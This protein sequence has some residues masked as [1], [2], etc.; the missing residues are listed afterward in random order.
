M[1]DEFKYEF[2]T[3][4]PDEAEIATQIE[5]AS[6]P[7]NE[8]CTLPTMKQRVRLASDIFL[9]AVNRE[10]DRRRQLIV[11]TCLEGK[12]K[13]YEKFGFHDCG[14]SGSVWGG[15]KWHEMVCELN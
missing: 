12:V 3:I 6:F 10:T 2:R 8:A 1:L 5:A 13:M 9:V 14:E 4:H 7:A 15:E 11:L